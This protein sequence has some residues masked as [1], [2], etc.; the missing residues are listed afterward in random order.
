MLFR[1]LNQI[2]I[3][4]L[5][6]TFFKSDK[7]PGWRGIAEKLIQDGKCIIVGKPSEQRIWIGGISNYIDITKA[8]GAIDCSLYSFDL[9]YFLTTKFF[10]DEHYYYLE[11][12]SKEIKRLKDDYNSIVKLSKPNSICISSFKTFTRL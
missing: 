4:F 5:S 12:V 8:E 6:N 9:D 10:E 3:D 7:F 2:Q 1:S 11:H